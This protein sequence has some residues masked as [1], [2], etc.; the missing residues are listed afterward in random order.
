MAVQGEVLAVHSAAL[1]GGQWVCS[2]CLGGGV[3][4]KAHCDCPYLTLSAVCLAC[5]FW[6]D[7]SLPV[8]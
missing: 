3:L 1:R 2:H 5:Q 7:D 8:L 4:L 6:W